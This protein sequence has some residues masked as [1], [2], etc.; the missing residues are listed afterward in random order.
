M[1]GV[2]H[3]ERGAVP[4]LPGRRPYSRSIQLIASITELLKAFNEEG[5]AVL[6]RDPDV[7]PVMTSQV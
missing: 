4:L 5:A 7:A 1:I 2:L 3:V 6:G